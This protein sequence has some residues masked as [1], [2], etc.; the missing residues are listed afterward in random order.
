MMYNLAC[1]YAMLNQKVEAFE[2][3][4][5]ALALGY[6]DLD[7]LLSDPDL[8]ALR[9]H[10]EF[11]RIVGK[12]PGCTVCSTSFEVDEGCVHE[13]RLKIDEAV[14]AIRRHSSAT[15]QVGIILGTVLPPGCSN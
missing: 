3:L 13:L 5:R 15:P 8:A 7:F 12:S 14:L 11:Q 10:P 4:H 2:A 9:G 1:S 6:A